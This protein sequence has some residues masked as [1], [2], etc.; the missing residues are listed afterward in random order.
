[1]T[2]LTHAFAH[3]RIT[4]RRA[5]VSDDPADLAR[6]YEEDVHLCVIERAPETDVAA[7]A[8]ALTASGRPVER[9][10]EVQFERYAFDRLLPEGRD[11]PGHAPWCRDVARLTALFC[12][13]FAIERVGLRL[14][15]LDHAMCSRFH[16][17][18]VP[19]RLVCT[20]GGIGT[21]WLADESVD[22]SK[23]GPGAG[24]LPDEASGLILNADAI[25][26]LPPYAIGLLKGARWPGNE[27]HGIVHRSP[28]PTPENPRRLLLTLDLL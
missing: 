4:A 9:I 17:D 13:L 6:I 1:M 23:L 24:G 19:A 18:H 7:F 12:D 3:P 16:V 11:L 22:R 10:E 25:Q 2:A 27:H 28:R 5:V 26:T 20:Y 14:R 8:E 15:V 21:Q